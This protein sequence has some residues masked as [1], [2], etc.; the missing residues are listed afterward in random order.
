MPATTLS[1]ATATAAA[2]ALAA[3]SLVAVVPAAQAAVV[4]RHTETITSSYVET[5]DGFDVRGEEVGQ[6][7]ITVKQRGDGGW[8][9][10]TAKGGSTTTWRAPGATWQSTNRF[11]FK[12]QRV[13]RVDGDLETYLVGVTQHFDVYDPSGHPDSRFD[14][15]VEW[16]ITFNTSTG[17]EVH[18][19]WTKDVGRYDFIGGSVCE[20][21]LRF[22]RL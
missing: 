14:R 13:L 6:Q 9:F 18:S 19:P 10:A 8:E 17:E 20:D 1:T 16:E 21:A 12:D 4:D 2:A 7:V 3:A 11:Q 22:G 5:C 15:R